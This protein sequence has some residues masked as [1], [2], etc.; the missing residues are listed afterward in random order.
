VLLNNGNGTFQDHVDFPTANG[1]LSVAVGDL[2]GDG[3]LDLAVACG[4]NVSLLF[5]K[6]DGTFQAHIDYGVGAASIALGDFNGDGKLDF[7]VVGTSGLT[8]FI[9]QGGG[10]FQGTTIPFGGT[11]GSR[12]SKAGQEPPLITSMYTEIVAADFNGD[13]KLD[14][15]V[16]GNVVPFNDAPLTHLWSGAGRN[17]IHIRRKKEK[18]ASWRSDLFRAVCWFGFADGVRRQ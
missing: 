4:N 7:A 3:K 16:A 6:D 14:L 13:G 18:E 1:P 8:L 5:G 9:N 11:P 10:N 2:N 15:A 17:R 12:H